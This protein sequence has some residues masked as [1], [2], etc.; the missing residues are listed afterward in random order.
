MALS[1]QAEGK[2]SVAGHYSFQQSSPWKVHMQKA[3]TAINHVKQNNYAMGWLNQ[4]NFLEQGR[5]MCFFQLKIKFNHIKERRIELGRGGAAV[6]VDL[7]FC[8]TQF[9][10]TV[11]REHMWEML[12]LCSGWPSSTKPSGAVLLGKV[13]IRHSME[14]Y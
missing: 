3:K 1:V 12:V 9:L 6:G 13:F 4:R 11:S 10:P 7:G 8:S 5:M 14:C 2:M